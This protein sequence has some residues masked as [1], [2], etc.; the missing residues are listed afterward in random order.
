MRI[1][2]P[3]QAIRILTRVCIVAVALEAVAQ[4]AAKHDDSGSQSASPAAEVTVDGCLY[5]SPGGFAVVGAENSYALHG[6]AAT[7]QK[8]LGEEVS[9]TG[10]AR[11]Q[12]DELDLTRIQTVFKAPVLWLPAAITDDSNWKTQVN[13]QYGVRFALPTLPNWSKSGE[14]G[15]G[16][17][18]V[19]QSGTVTLA[20]IG[21]PSEVYPSSNFIGGTFLLS[22]NPTITNRGSCEK[23]GTFDP[24]SVSYQN[25]GGAAYSETSE[26]DAAA[27]S[28]SDTKYLHTFQNGVCFE[29]AVTIGFYST[30]SQDFGCRVSTVGD[31]PKL[32]DEFTR[33]VSYFPASR[34]VAAPAQ[35]SVPRVTV[36]KASSEIADG[37]M[38]RGTITFSWKTENTDYVEFSYSCSAP[39]LGDTILEEGAR[40]RNCEN[41]PKPITPDPDVYTHSPNSSGQIVFGNFHH[42]DPIF[43]TVKIVP[44][45]HG[46][47]YPSEM[48]PIKITVDPYSPYPN[49]I[50][51]KTANIA[52]SYAGPVSKSYKQGEMLTVTW[53]DNLSRD[54]CVNLLLARDSASGVQYVGRV[55]EKCLSPAS[56]GSYNWTIPKKYAGAGFRVYA[57]APG[58]ESSALGPSFEIVPGGTEQK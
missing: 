56:S 44:F 13:G 9:V 53:T 41:D 18:F 19:L 50:P 46:K 45:S 52:L 31:A 26:G 49:G 42:D 58:G 1:F 20:N 7:L 5:G 32:V 38:N 35:E 21:I 6:D 16:T 27:G 37:A 2:N 51:S 29:V 14:L 22:V 3:G 55:S 34:K 48:E 39:G 23:F 24:R 30:A 25:I 28:S 33:R 15:T 47:A 11:A 12:S 54:S 40:S 4:T 17:N 10:V 8:H 57:S 36:F 43:V